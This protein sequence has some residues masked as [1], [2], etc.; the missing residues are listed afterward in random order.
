MLLEKP[1]YG[2]QYYKIHCVKS[3][4]IQCF[5]DPYFPTFGLNAEKCHIQVECGKMRSRKTPNTDIFHAVTSS[6]VE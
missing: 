6:S 5:F 4:R 2:V 1:Q 3:V